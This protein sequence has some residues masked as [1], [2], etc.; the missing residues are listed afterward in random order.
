MVELIATSTVKHLGLEYDFENFNPMQS[1]VIR[2]GGILQG[3]NLI[4]S[5]MTSAGK[6][7]L[8]EIVIANTVQNNMKSVIY[9]SP[10]KSLADEKKED[11]EK[12]FPDYK[13]MI[14]TGDYDLTAEQVK[15]LGDADIIIMTN[16]MLN[17]RCCKH[18]MEK[19]FWIKTNVGALIVD[20]AHMIASENRGDK[21]ESA[22]MDFTSINPEAQIIMLS[23][24]LSDL[25]IFKEWITGITGRATK[26]ISSSWRPTVLNKHLISYEGKSWEFMPKFYKLKKILEDY[27]KDKFIVFCPSRGESVKV[28][29]YLQN[30][31]ES[32]EYHN[33]SLNRT[34]RK[35]IENDFKNGN[36]RIIAATPTLSLGINAPARRVVMFGVHRGINRLEAL[37]IVQSCG[38][39]GRPRYDKDGDAYIIYPSS[40]SISWIDDIHIT[41]VMNQPR[42]LM[43]HINN[44]IYSKRITNIS[45]LEKWFDRTFAVKF[46]TVHPYDVKGGGPKKRR[47]DAAI[48]ALKNM[49]C[50]TVNGDNLEVT[51]LGDLA[52][53]MYLNPDDVSWW[54][55]NFNE[56]CRRRK[57]NDD[58]QLARAFI[59]PTQVLNE[60]YV[61]KDDI[62]V[63]DN[64]VERHL[65]GNI[66][67]SDEIVTGIDCLISGNANPKD[68]YGKFV[69]WNWWC[70][71]GQEYIETDD[72]R[73]RI[74]KFIQRN[75]RN[76]LERQMTC[77]KIL[78]G[79]NKWDYA[80]K[81]K[82]NN[83]EFR[84]IY[85]V[86]DEKVELVKIPT[87]GKV[88]AEKLWEKGIK[89]REDIIKRQ[90]ELI[91]I[92]GPTTAA[93]VLSY[94]QNG[95]IKKLR[96]EG[97]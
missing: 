76:D 22:I 84:M 69:M 9:L 43:F 49:G 34:E 4:V 86:S 17:S 19:N 30:N 90:T 79:F 66:S 21:L 27:P 97:E 38:R 81:V 78:A 41:S 68:V 71:T 2:D 8:A 91:G 67:D 36:L 53:R 42:T 7:V 57:L 72:K 65:G 82:L 95:T 47:L 93:K 89:N 96:S 58:V 24:T 73:R 23:A 40:E 14:L 48:N 85:G 12:L 5:A 80:D 63:V 28:C 54:N 70:L 94:V 31:G 26:I 35:K 75:I 10:M 20:E 16:E 64:F 6:T 3:E 83:L 1:E 39:A 13:I 87:V 15:S 25:D 33:A 88:T 55:R 77:I 45:E 32:I 92:L 11:W 29:E 46:I 50:I 62:P 51:K 37:E 59:H 18:D 44:A 60:P 74:I 61:R 56:L 52:A